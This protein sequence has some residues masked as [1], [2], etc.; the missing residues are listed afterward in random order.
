MQGLVRVRRECS[1]SSQICFSTVLKV[2]ANTANKYPRP[3]HYT[4]VKSSAWNCLLKDFHISDA[5]IFL[6]ETVKL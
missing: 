1:V 2:K 3:A 4:E 5:T 6:E